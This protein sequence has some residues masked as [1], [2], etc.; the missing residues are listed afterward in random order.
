[1]IASE[2]VVAHDMV[3]LAWLLENRCII[4]D[5]EKNSFTDTS[6]VLPKFANFLGVYWFG[7]LGQALTSESFDKNTVNTVWDDLV[8]NHA[9]E[10][11]GG[12]P[13]II[14]E[15]SNDMVPVDLKKR[16]NEM[17]MFPS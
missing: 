5:S 1:V 2:S 10:L 4:P 12:V 9:Y 11:F 7:G 8:L 6:K 13:G 16:L 14:L 17:T 3:S 15:S